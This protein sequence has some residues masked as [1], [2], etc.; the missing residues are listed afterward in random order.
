[1]RNLKTSCLV[2]M[3]LVMPHAL[4]MAPGLGQSRADA[5]DNHHRNA[6]ARIMKKLPEQ[7]LLVDNSQ[8][9]GLWIQSATVKEIGG[10]Q[11]ERLTKKKPLVNRY[12]SFPTVS[13]VNNTNKVITG[14]SLG[15]MN[16]SLNELDIHRKTGLQ[17]EPGQRMTLD[18]L[19]W[20]TL[21]KK[22]AHTSIEKDGVVQEDTSP[23]SWDF[24]G[25]WVVGGIAD[26]SFFVGQVDF[27]DGTTWLMTT[28]R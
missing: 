3:V 8:N 13:V 5:N 18:P 17:L 26:F 9:S 24:E 6:V 15:L 27:S 22:A 12:I 28:K 14:V 10:E 23:A 16:V 21:R 20:A 1:M 25:A 11:Y 7:N 2:A 19:I 4:S